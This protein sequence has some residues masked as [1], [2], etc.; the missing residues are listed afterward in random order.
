MSMAFVGSC[1]LSWADA[2]ASNDVL[3]NIDVEN[4]AQVSLVDIIWEKYSRSV[5]SP[6]EK[7]LNLVTTGHEEGVFESSEDDGFFK[8]N[9]KRAD[10][11]VSIGDSSLAEACTLVR[12][13]YMMI[14]SEV[15]FVGDI[16]RSTELPGRII[17]STMRAS[18]LAGSAVMNLTKGTVSISENRQVARANEVLEVLNIYEKEWRFSAS[19]ITFINPDR[20]IPLL[21]YTYGGHTTKAIF[22]D[23]ADRPEG[24]QLGEAMSNLRR[25]CPGKVRPKPPTAP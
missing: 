3:S 4:H 10:F 18:P 17:G 19:S 9:S 7:A 16:D 22:P 21:S 1:H 25:I 8:L 20:P 24:N 14:G 11:W 6:Q 5:K 13:S 23:P 2:P 12:Y 15:V